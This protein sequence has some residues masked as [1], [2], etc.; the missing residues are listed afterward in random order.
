[1]TIAIAGAIDV[2]AIN[3]QLVEFFGDW[4]AADVPEPKQVPAVNRSRAELHYFPS[5][6]LQSCLA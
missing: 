6:K 1:M 4:A 2:E 5:N 3:G